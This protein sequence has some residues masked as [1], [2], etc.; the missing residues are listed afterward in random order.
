MG[1]NKEFNRELFLFLAV[2]YLGIGLKNFLP[3]AHPNSNLVIL[4]NV[5]SHHKILETFRR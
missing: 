4:L 5:C 1:G 2:M 3:P